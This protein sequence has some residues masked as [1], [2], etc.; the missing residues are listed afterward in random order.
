MSPVRLLALL[1]LGV[2]VV[3]LVFLPDILQEVFP[4]GYRELISAAGE[5]HGV[6]WALIAAV[7][8]VESGFSPGVVSKKGAVGL[9][10]IMP[11]TAA[12]VGTRLG[13]RISQ[14]DLYNPQV[15]IELGTYYLRYLLDRFRTEQAALAAYNGGPANVARWLEEGVWDGTYEN[16][17][18]IP[19]A[20]TRSYVRK[21]SM[22]RSV[23]RFMYPDGIQDLEH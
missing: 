22:M 19:F 11:E 3:G 7:I 5:R 2:A 17:S 8:H 1:L 13:K 12:W 18:S 23:Y 21:V 14:E 16:A 15:N 4:L 20:E 10:Q 6:D 9:M